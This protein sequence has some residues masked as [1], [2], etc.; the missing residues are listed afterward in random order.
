MQAALPPPR[1]ARELVR[2]RARVPPMGWSWAAALV[3]AANQ[4]LLAAAAPRRAV[5]ARQG[6]VAG[7]GRGAADPGP[8]H[9]QLHGAGHRGCHN[10]GH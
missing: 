1:P 8:L 3:Q 6:A 5:V 9:R 2:V 4:H 7:A 10:G